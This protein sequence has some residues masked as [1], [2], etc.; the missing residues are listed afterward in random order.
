MVAV[1]VVI[2][3][4]VYLFRG[5]IN[6]EESESSV[7]VYDDEEEEEEVNKCSSDSRTGGSGRLR[8]RVST[9]FEDGSKLDNI[10]TPWLN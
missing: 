6:E 9:W 1:V 2:M 3:L 7:I 4:G 10:M 5:I 8:I